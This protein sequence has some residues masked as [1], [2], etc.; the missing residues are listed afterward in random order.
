MTI[1]KNIVFHW[2][3]GDN[4]RSIALQDV[5]DGLN[6]KIEADGKANYPVLWKDHRYQTLIVE[7]V[8]Q[9]YIKIITVGGNGTSR[10]VYCFL[11]YA[12]R[13]YKAA[14]WKAPAKWARGSIFDPDFG[15]GT[16]LGPYG[17]A[18]LR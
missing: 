9:K 15:W 7:H 8:G 16:A 2:T 3:G 5:L 6:A 4:D 17:A 14:S 13:I 1:A 12:G 18:Y 10:S 11:D